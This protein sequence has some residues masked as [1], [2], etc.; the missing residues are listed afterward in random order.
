[1][2]DDEFDDGEDQRVYPFDLEVRTHRDVADRK[3]EPSR[4]KEQEIC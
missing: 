1:M 2:F 4:M 3:V